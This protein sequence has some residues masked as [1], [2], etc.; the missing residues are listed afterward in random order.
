MLPTGG[1]MEIFMST[2]AASPNYNR[3]IY[4]SFLAYIVQAAVNN[5]APLLFL[6]FQSTYGIPLSGITMLVTFNFLIQLCIDFISSFIV[7][8]IGV[9]ICI[10][11]AHIAS[12]VGMICL[13]ILPD[14]L[15]NAYAGLIIS[16]MIYAL[17]GGLVEVLI[18]PI[19][20]SCPTDNKEKAMS[21][22]HSFYCWGHAGVIVTATLFF[23][24]AGIENWRYLAF[25]FGIFAFANAVSFA[26][27]PLAPFVEEGET[28]LSRGQLFKNKI[29][30]V[31]IIMI[32]CAGAS[33]QA[34]SQ[35]ASTFAERALNLSK[36][37]GDLAGPLMF[38]L[39]MGSSRLFYGKMGDRI[40]LDK[41]MKLSGIALVISY[42]LIVFSP[43]AVLSLIGCALTGLSVGIMWPGTFSKATASI[44]N[45][46]TILFSF[47]AL[48][49]DFGC[50][51]GPTLAGFVS[52]AFGENLKAGIGASIIFPAVLLIVIIKLGS[53]KKTA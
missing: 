28:G 4:S 31:I 30:W 32:A 12:G 17:G 10:V 23:K 38:A 15:P 21:L 26:S 7:D 25:A 36:T 44:K 6:T 39:L 9:R 45:G 53:R 42:L 40:D 20:E 5:F 13:G 2:K 35:W 37:A 41:F 22:L 14:L 51:A 50:T 34:V 47:M 27:A 1:G 46:G 8:R 24:I 29:F 16:V 48:A 11:G 33:E 52:D 49:G 19:V 43:F 18:S 3:T